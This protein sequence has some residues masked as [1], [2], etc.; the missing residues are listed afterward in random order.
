VPVVDKT[1]TESRTDSSCESGDDNQYVGEDKASVDDFFSK[2]G[3]EASI[4]R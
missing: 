2:L 1:E 3:E 4:Q